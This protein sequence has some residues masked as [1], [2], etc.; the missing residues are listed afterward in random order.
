MD[1]G[2]RAWSLFSGIGGLDEGLRRAGVEH[3]L[4]CEKDE[5]RREI[6]RRHFPGVDIR[7]DVA[8]LAGKP[9]D[10]DLLCGGFPC[11]DLS[12]AGKRAGLAGSESGLFF[13]FARLAESVRPRWVLVENVPGLFSSHDGRDFGVLIGTLADIGYGVAWRTVD[14]RYFGVPQRRRRVLIVGAAA[15]GDCRSGAERAGAVLSVGASCPRHPLSSAEEGEGVAAVLEGSPDVSSRVA[16]TFGSCADGGF[17]TIDVVGAYAVSENQRAEVLETTYAHQ[18]TAG[19]GKPGQGYSTVRQG[20]A[21]RRLMPVECER[22]QGLPDG[23]TEPGTATRRY[24]AIGDA[25]TVQVGE[26]VGR[27]LLREDRLLRAERLEGVGHGG[28]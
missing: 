5:W 19:G 18:L 26:W 24:A 15:S 12:V 10:A 22:L 23:W 1:E 8:A 21:V 4:L 7:E 9:G 3:A 2:L 16:G 11:T 17:R 20:M 13:E 28:G 25:V 27:A 14:S 6:L